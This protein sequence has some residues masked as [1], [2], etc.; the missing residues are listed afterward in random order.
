VK[1]G[2]VIAAVVLIPV[3]ILG[4]CAASKYN[5]I[6]KK[7]TAVEAKWADV[8]NQYKRRSDLIPQ[9]VEVVKGAKNFE[10]QTLTAVTQ[11]RAATTSIN[12]PASVFEDPAAA[13]R[14]LQ[15]QQGLTG[16]LRQ[17]FAVA[18]NY[19]ELKATQAFRDLQVQIEGTENRVTIARAD[20][21]E[22]V[23]EFNVA[24]RTFPGNIAA[25]FMGKKEIEQLT[26]VEGEAALAKPP[27]IDFGDK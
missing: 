9:L 18:E 3:L 2:L 5:E 26:F 1:A 11:A 20:Y 27:A 15:A 21:I 24:I 19:P 12:V 10:Q 4:G 6:V 13:A 22:A 7:E 17:L 23:R 25:K 16:A 8:Q 14:Y